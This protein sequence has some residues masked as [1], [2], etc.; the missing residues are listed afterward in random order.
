MLGKMTLKKNAL[1]SCKAEEKQYNRL[2]WSKRKENLVI[3]Q[4]REGKN[5]SLPSYILN[6]RASKLN[7]QKTLRGGKAYRFY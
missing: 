4:C 5:F 7:R 1:K 6:I 2:D 3:T